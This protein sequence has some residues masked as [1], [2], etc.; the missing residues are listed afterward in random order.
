[1]LPFTLVR[2]FHSLKV[3]V[4]VDSFNK[5]QAHN[6]VICGSI[7]RQGLNASVF[8]LVVEFVDLVGI[9]DLIHTIVVNTCFVSV[10]GAHTRASRHWV[11]VPYPS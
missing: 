6:T 5:L 7:E 10:I 3:H 1:M 9:K 11:E 8:R 4:F 2:T